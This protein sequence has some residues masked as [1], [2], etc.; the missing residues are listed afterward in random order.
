[1]RRKVKLH[2]SIPTL[3]LLRNSLWSELSRGGEEK[4]FGVALSTL[5]APVLQSTT[6]TLV[7]RREERLIA[8]WRRGRA[9]PPEAE[10]EQKESGERGAEAPFFFARRI[11]SSHDTEKETLGRA[12]VGVALLRQGVEDD[13]SVSTALTAQFFSAGEGIAA[14]R[15]FLP[16]RCCGC[17][18]ALTSMRR[19]R[20]RR[21]GGRQE[22]TLS[23]SLRHF[24]SRMRPF[25]RGKRK[26]PPPPS[27][28][29]LRN[30]SS[31]ALNSPRL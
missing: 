12:S 17:L 6:T 27:F 15:P 19:R 8:R 3:F 23:R 29:T 25:L 9:R 13:F 24:P 21:G 20:R 4:R 10:E 31:F 7:R 22:R 11:L 16:K 30:A 1:V 28:E 2:S 14:K 26:D 18:P 5:S